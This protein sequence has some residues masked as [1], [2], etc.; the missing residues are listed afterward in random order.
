M[1]HTFS[2][3]AGVTWRDTNVPPIFNELTFDDGEVVKSPGQQ[4]LTCYAACPDITLTITPD[5]K[6]AEGGSAV[7]FVDLGQGRNR[8]GGSALSTVYNQLGDES[9]DCRY[10]HVIITLA[11]MIIKEHILTH[12][13]F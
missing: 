10:T 13:F 5:L 7:L 6:T 9:P 12:H 8:L 3:D 4:T 11:I 1:V 2:V